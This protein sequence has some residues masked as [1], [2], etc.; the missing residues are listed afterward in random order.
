MNRWI[1]LGSLVCLFALTCFVALTG[2][3][4]GKTDKG[5]KSGDNAKKTEH[6]HGE[7]GPHGGPLADWDD[8]H[9]EF[10]VDAGKNQVIIYILDDK[11]KAAP[12]VDVA[13]ITDVKLTILE[14]KPITIELKH[15]PKL[16]SKDGIAFTGEHEKFAKPE[17]MKVNI[18][19]KVDG[20]PYSNP[21]TYAAPKKKTSQLYLT[22]GGIYTQADIEKN[23]NTTPAIKFKGIEWKHEDKQPGDKVCPITNNK[24]EAN[25]AWIVQGQRY[26]FCCT[27]C[28][29]KFIRWAHDEP[30]KIKNADEYIFKGGM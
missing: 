7:E 26:E 20:K 1:N 19:A 4:T 28:L 15:D 25:C 17:G 10:I 29:D 5:G 16:S 11:A 8:Y 18:A 21:V 13:K 27:P 23:G 9:G 12:K 24:A 14:A 3:N 30:A 6:D 2:C 22:P